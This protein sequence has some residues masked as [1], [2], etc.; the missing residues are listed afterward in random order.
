MTPPSLCPHS[1]VG[2]GGP[3]CRTGRRSAGTSA[4]RKNPPDRGVSEDSLRYPPHSVH[5]PGTTVDASRARRASALPAEARRS[6]IVEAALP[7]VLEHGERVTTKQIAEAAGIAEGTI[8]RV[9]EDKDAVIA[10]VV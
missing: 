9:F 10:A 4:G 5:A 8:F 7:L 6:M 3:D 2:R 1:Y